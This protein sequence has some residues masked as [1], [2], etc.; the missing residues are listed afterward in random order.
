MP[1]HP[2]VKQTVAVEYAFQ[3]CPAVSRAEI[4]H[5]K[6]RMAM[7]PM[8]ITAAIACLCVFQLNAQEGAEAAGEWFFRIE[9]ARQAAADRGVPILMVFSGSDW[10]RP[11]IQM[12]KE[13]W[14]DPAFLDYARKSLVL[15]QLDFPARR[16]NQPGPEQMAH[17]EALAEQYNPGG[18]FPN[19]VLIG[20]EG[21]EVAHFGYN[22]SMSAQ[23]YVE[24]LKAQI[25]Q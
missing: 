8:L 11:C 4:K 13:V 15:L 5:N 16:K 14:D 23:D 17:N 25:T 7:K 9:E 12:K 6:I 1:G 3:S 22:P 10:C 24:Y 18:E 2:F 20:R 19:A 21:K